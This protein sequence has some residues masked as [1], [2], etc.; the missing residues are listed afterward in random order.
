MRTYL[1][2]ISN[3]SGRQ[4]VVPGWASILSPGSVLALQELARVTFAIFSD[5]S[6]A[7]PTGRLR[8]GCLH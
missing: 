3:I 1:D 7:T 6:Q 4:E 2:T 8:T 5:G